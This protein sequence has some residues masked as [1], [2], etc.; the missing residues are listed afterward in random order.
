SP[1]GANTGA[2]SSPALASHP[3]MSS[4]VE[5]AAADPASR[6]NVVPRPGSTTLRPNGSGSLRRPPLCLLPP[7]AGRELAIASVLIVEGARGAPENYLPGFGEAKLRPEPQHPSLR[8]LPRG[9]GETRF[10][11][12]EQRR[13]H[14]V[15]RRRDANLRAFARDGAVDVVDLGAPS[16]EMIEEHRGLRI[17][18]RLAERLHV[19]DGI[20][21]LERDA[22]CPRHLI[23][24]D[25]ARRRD[26]P[27]ARIG[28]H[29]ADREAGQ[30][31]RT[32]VGAVADQL[33]PDHLVDV[34]EREHAEAA[35][36]PRLGDP[37]QPAGPPTR[38]F[39][40][41]HELHAVVMRVTGRPD[42]GA[43]AAD[44]ADH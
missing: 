10:P 7:A 4:A 38:H 18:D 13:H 39:A 20:R 44:D 41:A 17:G 29:L 2:Q 35:R 42:R 36:A 23:G 24:L 8:A 27:P 33:L 6:T 9:T 15:D 30:R 16:R 19:G 43:E 34:R 22:L 40:E 31:A 12:P 26:T 21:E 14:G 25:R 3:W 11:R 28:L 5:G 37:L 32:R 1:G